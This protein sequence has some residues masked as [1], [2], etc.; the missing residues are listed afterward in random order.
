MNADQIASLKRRL[1]SLEALLAIGA[2][3]ATDSA[4]TIHAVFEARDRLNE[5]AATLQTLVKPQ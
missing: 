2:D 3:P 4:T 5:I 1:S